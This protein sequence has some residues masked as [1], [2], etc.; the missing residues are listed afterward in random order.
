MVRAAGRFRNER[1]QQQT[2]MKLNGEAPDSIRVYGFE[3]HLKGRLVL[4]TTLQ[5]YIPTN[6]IN[7]RLHSITSERIGN[8][9]LKA[10]IKCVHEY[11]LDHRIRFWNL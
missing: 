11:N 4:Q 5:Q 6:G 7:C 2:W 10:A 9:E 1:R 8:P 3:S